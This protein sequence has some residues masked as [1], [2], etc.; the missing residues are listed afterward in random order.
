MCSPGASFYVRLVRDVISP[1][2]VTSRPQSTQDRRVSAIRQTR[3]HGNAFL[4][5][6]L[7]AAFLPTRKMVVLNALDDFYLAISLLITGASLV[8]SDLIVSWLP[9]FLLRHRMDVPL[10]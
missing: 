4:T 9:T 10:R 2:F 7:V 8:H 1:N 3:K 6:L 5:H